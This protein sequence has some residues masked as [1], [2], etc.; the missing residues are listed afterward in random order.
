M[1]PGRIERLLAGQALVR[2]DFEQPLDQLSR[3]FAHKRVFRVIEIAFLNSLTH[4][5]RGGAGERRAAAQEDV[6]DNTHRPQVALHP[7]PLARCLGGEHLRSN[8]EC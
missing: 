5:P 4:M 1:K 8:I 2:V 6:G 3:T 7:I